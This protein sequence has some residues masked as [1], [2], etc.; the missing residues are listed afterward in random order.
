[1]NF[2]DEMLL[3]HVYDD[4]SPMADFPMRVVEET[5]DRLVAWLAPE[6]EI[7]YWATADGKDPR[8]LPLQERFRSTMS[9]ARRQWQGPGVLR[10]IFADTI[11]QVV[12]FWTPQGEFSGWYVNFEAT[13]RRH[14]NQIL[15]TDWQLDLW[16]T[17]ERVGQ[18]KDEDE[19]LAAI[20]AGAL[21]SEHLAASFAVGHEILQDFDTFLARVGDWREWSPPPSWAAMALPF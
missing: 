6:S 15:T 20:D 9:T 8:S 4:G 11:Y 1:V 21:T 18:W 16:I 12:H 13:S 19:A 14:G 5:S 10:V 17:P 2:G 3:S 7:R